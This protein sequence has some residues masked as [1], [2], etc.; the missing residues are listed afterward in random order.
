M[1]ERS[2][3]YGLIGKQIQ[4]NYSTCCFEVIIIDYSGVYKRKATKAE[5]TAHCKAMCDENRD[6]RNLLQLYRDEIKR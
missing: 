6:L 3:D 4:Y 2:K 5:I 1:V